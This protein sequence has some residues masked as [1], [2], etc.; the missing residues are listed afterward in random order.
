MKCVSAVMVPPTTLDN[1][2]G[3][4]TDIRLYRVWLDGIIDLLT[5]AQAN[6]RTAK[7]TLFS[8]S[9]VTTAFACR[10]NQRAG[11]HFTYN[12]TYSV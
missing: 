2:M 1:R 12:R 4:D 10:R 3:L 7:K 8:L 5:D 11:I 9:T 6:K